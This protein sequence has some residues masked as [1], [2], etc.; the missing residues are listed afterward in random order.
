MIKVVEPAQFSEMPE[1]ISWK[2]TITMISKKQ[3]LMS[4][5]QYI[6]LAKLHIRVYFAGVFPDQLPTG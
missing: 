6:E 1:D 5:L 3:E 4:N 2:P